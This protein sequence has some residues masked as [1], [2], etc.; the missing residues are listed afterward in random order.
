MGGACADAPLISPDF[1]GGPPLAAPDLERS[2]SPD[3]IVSIMLDDLSGRLLPT[4]ADPAVRGIH[5]SLE[6]ASALLD[7][8]GEKSS[9]SDHVV[10]ARRELE[11]I[12][13][14]ESTSGESYPDL[15]AARMVLETVEAVLCS[16]PGFPS[17]SP[18]ALTS[19][20]LSTQ[21]HN[22]IS[23]RSVGR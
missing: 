22:A 19:S 10:R 6:S 11:R 7:S 16:G 1:A 13:R 2:Q 17:I 8:G 12:L 23:N 20:E 14:Q 21:E 9:A 4:G 18:L 3:G 15:E 5:S